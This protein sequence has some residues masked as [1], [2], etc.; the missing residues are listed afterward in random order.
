[1]SDKIVEPTIETDVLT[2][3]NNLKLI[4]KGL[5]IINAKKTP[6]ENQADGIKQFSLESWEIIP[7]DFKSLITEVPQF[8]QRSTSAYWKKIISGYDN[9]FTKYAQLMLSIFTFKKFDCNEDFT[10]LIDFEKLVERMEYFSQYIKTKP[11]VFNGDLEK[12]R[13]LTPSHFKEVTGVKWYELPE[14]YFLEP[15]NIRD[16]IQEIIPIEPKILNSIFTNDSE[17]FTAQIYPYF[18]VEMFTVSNLFHLKLI[19]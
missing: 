5:K 3:V 6:S 8:Y 7:D 11:Y 16:D 13:F 19:V 14:S 9:V 2:R 17:K 10:F 1:M 18:K 15:A 4:A 12:I